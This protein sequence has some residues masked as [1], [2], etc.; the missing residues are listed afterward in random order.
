MNFADP[1]RE[2]R[3]ESSA[4]GLNSFEFLEVTTIVDRRPG[5]VTPV[6]PSVIPAAP[7]Q[8]IGPFS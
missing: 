2:H 1:R 3:W 5:S 7:T 8:I 6:S 4:N